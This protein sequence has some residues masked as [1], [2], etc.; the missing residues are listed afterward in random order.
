MDEKNLNGLQND[1]AIDE[2]AENTAAEE[3]AECCC[4]CEGENECECTDEVCDCGCGCECDGENECECECECTDE[5]C[6]C[7]CGC[8]CDG[9]GEVIEGGD[10]VILDGVPYEVKKGIGG[11]QAAI[12]AVGAVVVIL[13]AAAALFVSGIVNPYEWGYV[14]TTGTTL[15]ELADETGFTVKEYK[16]LMDLPKLMPGAT[17]ENA[18]NNSVK[19]G[20]VISQSGMAFDDFK[21]YYGWGDDVTEESTVGEALGKTKLSIILGDDEKTLNSFREYYHFDENVTGETLYGDVREAIDKQ[22]RDERIEEEKSEKEAEK[23]AEK[24]DK[25]AEADTD[26][27]DKES[28]TEESAE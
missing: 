26:E 19:I 13:L 18:V 3:T 4:G 17:H 23:E 16:E 8:G 10:T 11:V 21:Q 22:T 28:E 24:E 12:I 27:A 25:D 15:R 14:D 5:A 20:T 6:D 2:T 1:E 9:N 7:G